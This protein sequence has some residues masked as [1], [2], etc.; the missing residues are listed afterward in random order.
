[1]LSDA[2]ILNPSFLRDADSFLAC[3]Q[4]Y[5][6]D[7]EDSLSASSSLEAVREK[8]LAQILRAK[9]ARES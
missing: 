4:A 9:E 5:G 2:V 3:L 7:H 8:R 1:M 6:A